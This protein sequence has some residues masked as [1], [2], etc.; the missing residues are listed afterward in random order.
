M[1][2]KPTDEELEQRVAALAR[3][4][5]ERQSRGQS[6]DGPDQ[7][8]SQVVH[9]MAIP[10]FVL[11]QAHIVTHWNKAC[12]KLTGIASVDMVGTR[13][14]WKAFYPEKRPVL[15]ELV[16]DGSLEDA[17]ARHYA[18]K[19]IRSQ[20]VADA[21]EVQDFFSHMGEGGKW[22]F[23]TA[24]AL[25]DAS[26]RIMGAIETFQ[27]LTDRK[28]YEKA[29]REGEEKLRQITASAQDA[30]VMMDDQGRI[31]F[32]NESAEKIFGYSVNEVFGKELHTI[33]APVQ[34]K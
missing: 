7:N 8:L 22:L 32:W 31:T 13:N 5:S 11:N 34:F 10:A 19:Y 2:S 15:A 28:R 21:Y 30:I 20:M 16:I 23:F 18:G 17:V 24:T 25:R 33:L 12:E 14:A 1:H 3:E 9:G 27:D 29:L 6:H 26:N 4:A